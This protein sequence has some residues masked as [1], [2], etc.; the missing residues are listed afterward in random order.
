[1]VSQLSFEVRAV[2]RRAASRLTGFKRRLFVA[3]M[4]IEHCQASPRQTES[5]LGF[6]RHTVARGLQELE[7]GKPIRTLPENRRRPRI[8]QQQPDVAS[9]TDA[10]LSENSQVDNGPEVASRRT[11]F[12]KRLVSF[13]DKHKLTIEL[14]Y[15]PPYHSKYDAV[16]HPCNCLINGVWVIPTAILRSK[17]ASSRQVAEAGETKF[18]SS[19]FAAHSHPLRL[20]YSLQFCGFVG[21]FILSR[22][23][24]QNIAWVSRRPSGT[25]PCGRPGLIRVAAH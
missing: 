8:E 24:N 25:G 6:N 15:Y 10:M 9:F 1:M 3:E 11:Q 20:A 18:A 22:C 5:I 23:L 21:T 7:L 13:A 16:V 4:A 19:C 2:I 17:I 12:M 14:V